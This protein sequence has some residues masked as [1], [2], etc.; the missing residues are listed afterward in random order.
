MIL[1]ANFFAHDAVV[2]AQELLGKVLRVK[3]QTTWLAALII[4]TEAYYIYDKASHASLGYTEKRKALFMSPGTI[5]MYY[6]RGGDSLNVSCLGEGN[7]VLIKA[8]FPY[9]TAPALTVMQRLNPKRDHTIRSLEKLC[10]GQ[11]LLCKALGLKVKDWDKKQFNQ[12]KFY[13]DDIG[14]HPQKIMRTQRLGI[15]RGRDEHLPYRFVDY[16]YARFCTKNPLL[17]LRG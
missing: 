2:V 3:Y 7:A 5:Y 1:N 17:T 11:T 13:I 4:E 9:V 8:G 14:Y 15:P 10:A 16:E 6:S 12:K